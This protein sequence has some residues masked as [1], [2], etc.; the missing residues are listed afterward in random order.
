MLLL[1]HKNDF[2]VIVAIPKVDGWVWIRYLKMPNDYR[3]ISKQFCNHL[4]IEQR[5]PGPGDCLRTMKIFLAV[6]KQLAE[7]GYK[8]WVAETGVT[9]H[10]QMRFFEHQGAK[11]YRIDELHQAWFY[12]TKE[13]IMNGGT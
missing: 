10:K 7:E 4:G 3:W 9:N 5:G 6:E 11:T 2:K 13:Q 1:E 12:K 8:G